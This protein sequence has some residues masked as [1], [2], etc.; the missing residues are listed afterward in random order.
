MHTN[1]RGATSAKG[2]P[3]TTNAE[4][5]PHPAAEGQDP[6]MVLWA[7]IKCRMEIVYTAAALIF[8]AT[9][10]PEECAKM[11]EDFASE[12]MRRRAAMTEGAK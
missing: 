10:N 4:N 1:E 8:G 9:P 7:D 12:I 6:D 11:A 3:S 2:T 5:V